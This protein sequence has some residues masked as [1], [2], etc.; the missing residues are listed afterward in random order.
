MGQAILAQR[1]WGTKERAVGCER[2]WQRRGQRGDLAASR[3]EVRCRLGL[4]DE[5]ALPWQQMRRESAFSGEPWCKGGTCENGDSC[6]WVGNCKTL[7]FAR[8]ERAREAAVRNALGAESRNQFWRA[9]CDLLRN[10]NFAL[11]P[12]LFTKHLVEEAGT[13]L[14][15]QAGCC[16][17]LSEA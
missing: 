8:A 11:S 16:S 12:W 4:E 2:R 14:I 1:S 10:V 3:D 6:C 5:W 15:D 7:K 17:L 13:W 9:R